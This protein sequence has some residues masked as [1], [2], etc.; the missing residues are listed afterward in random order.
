MLE[1][2][3]EN[4][5]VTR[6]EV[7]AGLKRLEIETPPQRESLPDVGI[8]LS[9]MALSHLVQVG[10]L[11]PTARSLPT[12]VLGSD[13]SRL[14]NDIESL[15]EEEAIATSLDTLQQAVAERLT[16]AVWRT[17][18]NTHSLKEE[19]RLASL[20]VHVRCLVDTLPRNEAAK[21]VLFWIEDRALSKQR[22]SEAV[23][24]TDILKV[25]TDR[26]NLSTA[27]HEAILR[28]MWGSGYSFLPGFAQDIVRLLEQAAI[29]DAEIVENAALSDIRRWF[30]TQ[31][32]NLAYIDPNVQLDS[33]GNVAGETRQLVELA[34]LLK[35]VLLIIWRTADQIVEQKVARSAWASTCLRL[36]HAPG[37]VAD[38]SPAGRRRLASMIAA[39]V[40]SLPLFAEL[41]SEEMPDAD[42]QTYINWAVSLAGPSRSADPE[43]FDD[44][45]DA[46]AGMAARI[47]EDPPD[48]ED[49]IRQKLRAHMRTI[50]HRFLSLLP[51]KWYD[52][53]AAR[54]GVAEALGREK[55]T[56]LEVADGLTVR[57]A[58]LPAAIQEAESGR[59]NV[60]LALHKSKAS[61]RLESEVAE[62]DLP[63]VT[64]IVKKQR[65]RFDRTSIALVHPDAALREKALEELKS[66][67]RVDREISDATARAI[68]DET[69][70]DRRVSLFDEARG[71]EFRRQ[72]EV[73]RERVRN[74]RP[75][76]I[77][78]FDL[79]APEVLL[80][81]LGLS[82]DYRGNGQSLATDAAEALTKS[83]GADAAL[84]RLSGLPFQLPQSLLEAQPHLTSAENDRR[85]WDS[86]L[87][88]MNRFLAYGD[89]DQG[90]SN[91][92]DYF[93][94]LVRAGRGI[95]S[96]LVRRTAKR[97]SNDASW[98]ALPTDMV[99][100]LVWTF[101]EH[102]GRT[103]LPAGFK[104]SSFNQWLAQNDVATFT[105]FDRQRRWPR[106]AREF[107]L[108]L[109]SSG[110]EAAIVSRLLKGGMEPSEGL[111]ALAGTERGEEWSPTPEA[112]AAKLEAPTG[113]WPAED[114]IPL[115][116]DAGWLPADSPFSLRSDTAMARRIVQEGE[117]NGTFVGPALT[118]LVDVERVDRDVLL[119]IKEAISKRL[120]DAPLDRTEPAH[121]A[122][123]EVFAKV[124]ALLGDTELFE[125]TITS[126]ASANS[127]IW[128]HKRLRAAQDD[129][130]TK[131]FDALL[132]SAQWF[133][134]MVGGE[135]P[136][137]M[138]H[139][140]R[141]IRRIVDAWP[142]SVLAAISC[143]DVVV[144][145]V[146]ATT[147]A[148]A[149]WPALMELR[150]RR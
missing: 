19:D 115:Y 46:L 110:F 145:K 80:D 90:P 66:A 25:L 106:W 137:Q 48:V 9:P 112:A 103:V 13:L 97:A 49:G 129:E 117:S 75:L 43:L 67:A 40:I 31:A 140:A 64:M 111:K 132:H 63:T 146:D 29:V 3:F 79:P 84:E 22:L 141:N 20:P 5:H 17:R 35:E 53:I 134:A 128:P 41:A 96:G 99:V 87:W 21:G 85:Y 15:R 150:T 105:E 130:S 4:G 44:I 123:L 144:R 45:I 65:Y 126:I 58:D 142:M 71:G 113:F 120:T 121:R 135:L 62:D 70:I 7:A 16:N 74:G 143:L 24:L 98:Q 33:E 32:S 14:S 139:F 88:A 118:V 39:Q 30:A 122:Q 131:A 73:L 133:A 76:S 2:A 109:T 61:C 23:Y 104:A 92:A 149:L 55:V 100:A 147:A 12:Y 72:I 36:E 77:D 59:K 94:Q 8:S 42:R 1:H 125:R 60:R 6:D 91:A 82:S 102:I 119:E 27:R 148:E 124:C 38:T 95:F 51:H 26:G 78:A 108:N 54:R 34:T 50:V 114:P 107:S 52:A 116:I 138:Q 127:R 89:R 136:V 101:A 69:D 81:F 93:P 11:E 86:P 28:D 18:P 10:A 47:V 56:I 37:G 68:L 83:L 57:I